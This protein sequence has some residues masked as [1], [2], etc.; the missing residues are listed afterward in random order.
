MNFVKSLT[1]MTFL[2]LFT[3]CMEKTNDHLSSVD[4][5]TNRMATELENDRQYL[6]T[7]TGQTQILA[8]E[9][10]NDRQ[11][12]KSTTEQVQ[13]MNKLIARLADALESI[14]KLGTGVVQNIAAKLSIPN[15]PS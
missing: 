6:K 15:G 7:A 12:L 2:M 3:G 11:Y 13:E 4:N 1:L 14:N 5:N 10:Q 9:F 8:N